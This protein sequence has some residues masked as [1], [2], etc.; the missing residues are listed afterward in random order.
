M[1]ISKEL[2]P[3][4]ICI[5]ALTSQN[6]GIYKY[7][8]RLRKWEQIL[9]STL[10]VSINALAITRDGLLFTNP[11]SHKVQ[12]LRQGNIVDIAGCS[13]VGGRDGPVKICQFAQPMEICIENYC[14]IYVAEAQ[15]GTIAT[16]CY[17]LG[18]CT[19]H[20]VFIW[21]S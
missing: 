17:N 13:D 8:P 7:S 11:A 21:C 14:N 2:L 4:N 20:L 15:T 10:Y 5:E 19:V 3:E 9:Q 18:S 1:N 12:M 16:F 6:G